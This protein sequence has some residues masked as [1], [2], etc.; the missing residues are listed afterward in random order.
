MVMNTPTNQWSGKE[1][2]RLSMCNAS[3]RHA[4]DCGAASIVPKKSA[5]TH[6]HARERALAGHP[7]SAAEVVG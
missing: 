2:T 4:V 5:L 3:S 7:T 6:S 1:Q